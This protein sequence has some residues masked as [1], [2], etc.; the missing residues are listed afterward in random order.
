MRTVQ[1]QEL[2]RDLS[3][4]LE[5]VSVGARILIT[6]HNRPLAM[7]TPVPEEGVHTGARF[8]RAPLLPLA[9]GVGA[10]PIA[11]T[12]ADDRGDDR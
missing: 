11:T 1:I 6:R 7:L 2:K 10:R 3:G 5:E 4:L 12:L 8:G 9:A